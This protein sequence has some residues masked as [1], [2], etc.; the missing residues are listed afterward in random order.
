MQ[1]KSGSFQDMTSDNRRLSWY[2]AF[3]RRARKIAHKGNF[4]PR[5][6]N[7]L[8]RRGNDRYQLNLLLSLVIS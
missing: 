7:F 3:P 1:L 6:A 4:F 8:A 5:C 2:L